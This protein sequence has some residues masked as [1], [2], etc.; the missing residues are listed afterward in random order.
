MKWSTKAAIGRSAATALIGAILLY[1][2]LPAVVVALT[3]FTETET[4][5]F[6]PQGF[7][8]RW[9]L[10]ALAYP[11]FQRALQNSLLIALLTSIIATVVGTCFAYLLERHPFPGRRVM[12]SILLSP[13][14]IPHFVI[15]FSCL[16]LMISLRVPRGIETIVLT[17]VI[18]VTP[19][20]VRSVLVSIRA[21]DAELEKAAA[22]L[23]APPLAVLRHVTLPLMA[24]GIFGG[25]L[26][27]T[28]LSFTEFSGS[29]FVSSERTQPLPVAMYGYIRDYADPTVAALST[30]FTV[31][32]AILLLIA[33][34]WFG[35]ANI[36]SVHGND[37]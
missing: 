14:V 30:L 1:L 6:P 34:R 24:P 4:L 9:H 8:W 23:G 16:V 2:S 25:W 28:I 21:L 10:K 17:H 7:T 29:L 32:I 3:S 31:L 18:I 13:L 12:T 15:G 36:L 26:F 11:E 19:F 22:S 27:A 33:A 20:V 37:H 5:A 35:L